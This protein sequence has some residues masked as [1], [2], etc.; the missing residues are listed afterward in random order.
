MNSHLTPP[1][2][3]IFANLMASCGLAVLLLLA[4]GLRD[5]RLFSQFCLQTFMGAGLGGVIV[6]PAFGLQNPIGVIWS[7]LGGVL[8][9]MIGAALAM[10]FSGAL[11]VSFWVPLFVWA[12]ILASPGTLILWVV[13]MMG[14]HVLAREWRRGS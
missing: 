3:L 8:A 6:S 10:V 9:T 7:F 4:I 11:S 2:L 1:R 13:S 12:L 5:P 14:L